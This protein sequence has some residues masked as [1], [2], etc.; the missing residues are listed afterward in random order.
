VRRSFLPLVLELARTGGVRRLARLAR[1]AHQLRRGRP[2]KAPLFATLAVTYRCNYACGM[3][4][5]PARAEEEF[6]AREKLIALIDELAR[7][8]TLAVGLT[9]GEPMLRRDLPELVA[10]AVARGLLCHVNTNGSCLGAERDEALLASRP[11]SIN[12]SLDGARAATHDRLR[13]VPGSFDAVTRGVRELIALRDRRRARTRV[14]LVMALGPENAPETEDFAALG[15]ALGVDGVG[16][17]PVHALADGERASLAPA[18]LRDLSDRLA[19]IRRG[20]HARLLD[21]SGRYL[22][23]ALAFLDGAS[24]PERCSAPLGHV[25]IDPWFRAY[26]CVPLMTLDRARRPEEAIF[27]PHAERPAPPPEVCARC[28]W[29]CHRELDLA[30]GLL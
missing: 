5:F 29:N 21:N 7:R 16:F 19:R 24:M 25:A 18:A 2:T 9:G 28:W 17:L 23:G 6:P 20:P 14:R 30:L 1:N 13:G 4:D 27:A 26:P 8:G 12:I 15:A 22:D 3:C 10:H 11:C